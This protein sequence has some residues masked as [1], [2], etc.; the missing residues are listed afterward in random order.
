MHSIY[1]VAVCLPIHKVGKTLRVLIFVPSLYIRK[2][3]AQAIN[4]DY[5][6]EQNKRC[7]FFQFALKYLNPIRQALRTG[8]L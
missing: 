4:S 6:A 7:W 8:F 2:V 1:L 5:K 3:F